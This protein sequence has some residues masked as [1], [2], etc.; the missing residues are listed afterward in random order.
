MT[1]QKQK[2][3]NVQ[4]E[5][6]NV[7]VEQARQSIDYIY[8]GLIANEPK[9]KINEQVFVNEF[10]P[11][12]T[13]EKDLDPKSNLLT[14]WVGIAGNASNEVDVVDN[15]GEILFSVPGLINTNLLKIGDRHRD[16][17]I[18]ARVAEY[19]QMQNILPTVAHGELMGHLDRKV[20][21][22]LPSNTGVIESRWNNILERYGKIKPSESSV[23]KIDDDNHDDVVYE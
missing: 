7:I 8:D 20:T 16:D 3:K 15:K 19:T 11:Y 23:K 9:N 12:L 6:R 22:I 14:T 18:I 13:G 4:E 5:M 21:D 2:V 17:S 10:L 1:D